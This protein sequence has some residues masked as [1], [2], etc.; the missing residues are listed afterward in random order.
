MSEIQATITAFLDG[1]LPASNLQ[2]ALK[3]CDVAALR[4][5]EHIAVQSSNALDSSGA[6]VQRAEALQGYIKDAVEAAEDEARL[7]GGA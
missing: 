2:T 3:Q 6:R 1:T 5:A 7:S 4:E